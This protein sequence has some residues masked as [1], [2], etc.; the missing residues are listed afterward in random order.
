MKRYIGL[1]LCLISVLSVFAA[2]ATETE[3]KKAIDLYKSGKYED[4]V[5]VYETMLSTK[6]VSPVIYYNLANAYFK[7]GQNARA[8]LN[9]ERA[10]QLNPNYDDAKFNLDLAKAKL[11]DKVED[12]GEFFMISFFKTI[13]SILSS[14][15]WAILSIIL[16]IVSLLSILAY[17]FLTQVNLRKLGF[18]SSIV[19]FMLMLF[20]FFMSYTQKSRIVDQEYAIVISPSVTVTSTPDEQG[21]KLFVVHEGVKVKIKEEMDVWVEV[22]LQDGN[23]GWIKSTDIEKI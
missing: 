1:F 2:P 17:A 18:Y 15:A 11:T 20:T 23:V 4:A 12:V 19:C 8:I 6:Q 9:Y 22:Q 3:Q 10:L 16:F 13:A 5:S 14:N 21:T 7:S